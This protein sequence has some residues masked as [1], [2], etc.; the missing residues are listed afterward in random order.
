MIHTRIIC[1]VAACMMIGGMIGTNTLQAQQRDT[2]AR[3]LRTVDVKAAKSRVVMKDDQLIFRIDPATGAGTH[4]LEVLEQLPGV[5][6]DQDNIFR[7][8]IGTCMP[9]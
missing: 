5:R 2:T 3:Q 7:Q 1:T 8:V 4:A 6:V 9:G